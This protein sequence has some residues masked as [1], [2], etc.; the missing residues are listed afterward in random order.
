MVPRSAAT[1]NELE[2][3]KKSAEN[4]LVLPGTEHLS[5]SLR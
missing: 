4:F 2:R 1:V 5:S 3:K